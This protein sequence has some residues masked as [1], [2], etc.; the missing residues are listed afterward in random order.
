MT[1]LNANSDALKNISET[2]IGTEITIFV[3][4]ASSFI[5][6]TT[7][8]S[9]CPNVM[10]SFVYINVKSSCQIS[11]WPTGHTFCS[12]VNACASNLLLIVQYRSKTHEIARWSRG[13]S[14]QL[15]QFCSL[16]DELNQ[17]SLEEE[18][19]LNMQGRRTRWI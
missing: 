18:N 3:A 17:T 19:C 1:H 9:Q 6:G 12:S 16:A 11:V 14:H 4:G 2:E 13:H 10:S 8:E 15:L 7:L 5:K